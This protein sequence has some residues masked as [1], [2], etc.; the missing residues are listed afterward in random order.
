MVSLGSTSKVMVFPV[1]VLTKICMLGCLVF[2]M[3]LS[4]LKMFGFQS[5]SQKNENLTGW[6]SSIKNHPGAFAGTNVKLTLL[7]YSLLPMLETETTLYF[8]PEED[9]ILY[10]DNYGHFFKLGE[11]PPEF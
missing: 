4:L 5:F 1:R 11:V 6:M 2:K 8:K 7:P 3:F 10:S 9:N